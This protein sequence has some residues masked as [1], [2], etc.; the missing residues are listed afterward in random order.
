MKSNHHIL[1]ARA[2]SDRKAVGVIGRKLA[3]RL[4]HNKDLV[5]LEGVATGL[6][7]TT[8]GAG[9]GCFVLLT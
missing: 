2:S 8:S 1:V 5:G 3:Q 4:N 9:I 7:R 6:G